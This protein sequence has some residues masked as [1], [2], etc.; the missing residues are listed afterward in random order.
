MSK[1]P[2]TPISFSSHFLAEVEEVTRRVDASAIERM[3]SLLAR[4]RSGRV[5]SSGRASARATPRTPSAISGNWQQFETY[6]PT[7]NVSEL[8]A[9]VND[10]GWLTVE[11]ASVGM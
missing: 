4:E 3:A 5:S 7:D 9:R 6:A 8:T 2:D 10:E 1:V 11:A